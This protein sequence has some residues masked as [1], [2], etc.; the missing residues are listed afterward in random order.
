MTTLKQ[1]AERDCS[2]RTHAN[3]LCAA[4]NSARYRATRQDPCEC[5][6]GTILYPNHRLCEPCYRI[7]KRADELPPRE[8]PTRPPRKCSFPDCE[9]QGKLVRDLC[10]MHYRR[11]LKHGDPSVVLTQP[12]RDRRCSMTGCD[13]K[14]YSRNLC[15]KHYARWR[16]HGDPNIVLPTGRPKLR[17]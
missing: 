1:C 3:G 10:Q 7:A 8:W 9:K 15:N 13:R 12:S 14:H 11:W 17:T 16:K 5:G 4:H 6:S 2:K